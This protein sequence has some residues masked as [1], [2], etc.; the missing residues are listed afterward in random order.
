MIEPQWN[1]MI[2]KQA[3]ARVIRFGQTEKV[4]LYRYIMKDTIEE[5]KTLEFSEFT[6][7]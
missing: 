6:S 3:F 1:P 5:V 4:T 7:I 2:E